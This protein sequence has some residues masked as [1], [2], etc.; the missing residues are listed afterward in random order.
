M[1]IKPQIFKILADIIVNYIGE[2]YRGR[3]WLY[4]T[5]GAV[6]ILSSPN[7][8]KTFII[9]SIN[10]SERI[11]ANKTYTF[12]DGAS[13]LLQLES[14]IG[15]LENVTLHVCSRADKEGQIE[16]INIC[17]FVVDALS[18]DYCISKQ[19]QYNILIPSTPLSWVDAT[20]SE[21]T[22]LITRFD[23]NL[24]VTNWYSKITNQDYYNEIVAELKYLEK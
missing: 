21:T 23:I 15:V 9:V 5:V 18:S 13:P 4:N 19:L 12:I 20:E 24:Q 17:P 22:Q 16:A 11:S 2:E 1:I 14:T 8:Y 3:I 10:R 6:S 7:D